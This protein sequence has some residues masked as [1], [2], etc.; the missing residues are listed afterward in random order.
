MN[1]ILKY[2][3]IEESLKKGM[4]TYKNERHL[5]LKALPLIMEDIAGYVKTNPPT[6][7][8]SGNQDKY[9]WVCT[10]LHVITNV[11]DVLNVIRGPQHHL[12]D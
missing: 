9:T 2:F 4:T 11:A 12:W 5:D 8:Q 6:L 7:I 10:S 3:M 1:G